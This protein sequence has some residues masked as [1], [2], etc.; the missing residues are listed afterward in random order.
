LTAP[1]HLLL[2]KGAAHKRLWAGRY[3]GLGGHIE[4]GEDV[5]QAA[6]RE[7]EE[8]TGLTE[9]DLHLC[10]TM[11]VDTGTPTGVL[12]FVFRGFL[13][14]TPPVAAS[15]EGEPQWVPVDGVVN[16]PLVDDLFV[17]LPRV[18]AWQPGQEPFHGLITTDADGLPRVQF[19]A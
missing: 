7:L 5:L 6:R 10:G 8:E 11:M 16:L 13:E 17:L 1:Q 14:D 3:N 2:L 18:L 15:D 4:P 9:V 12:L 19:S